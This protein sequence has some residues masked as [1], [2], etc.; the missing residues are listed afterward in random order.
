MKRKRTWLLQDTNVIVTVIFVAC[1]MVFFPSVL[2]V[3]TLFSIISL[4]ILI[5]LLANTDTPVT[6]R[7]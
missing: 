6:F 7:S 3:S 4:M 1:H 2:V 5:A